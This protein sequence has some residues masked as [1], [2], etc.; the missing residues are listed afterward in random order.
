MAN[1]DLNWQNSVE[2]RLRALGMTVDRGF[3]QLGE[4]LKGGNLPADV[5]GWQA[6]ET[7]VRSLEQWLRVF[8]ST[9]SQIAVR[10]ERSVPATVTDKN[11][12]ATYINP[13]KE[14]TKP[15]IIRTNPQSITIPASGQAYAKFQIP[16]EENLRGDSEIFSLMLVAATSTS[17]RIE[18][19]HTGRNQFLQNKP[20]HSMAMFGNMMSGPQPFILYESIFLEPGQELL[21]TLTDFSQAPNTVELVAQARRFL[22]YD[23]QHLDRAGLINLFYSRLSFPFWLTSDTNINLPAGLTGSIQTNY[24]TD[25]AF[26]IEAGKMMAAG[27]NTLNGSPQVVPCHVQIQEGRSGRYLTDN[28]VHVNALFGTSNFPI[29][30]FEPLLIKRGTTARLTVNNDV[31]GFPDN[32]IDLVFHGRALPY[33]SPGTRALEQVRASA[34]NQGVGFPVSQKDVGYPLPIQPSPRI[35]PRV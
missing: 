2:R 25:Q 12:G 5:P 10:P 4:V 20:I 30:L 16:A 28:F 33:R 9:T 6:M 32:S 3:A 15:F 35:G 7:R 13:V 22:G 24:T 11:T 14:I 17:F 29:I 31:N 18:L 8:D 26:D 34:V 1:N 23:T 21:L 19:T 27:S